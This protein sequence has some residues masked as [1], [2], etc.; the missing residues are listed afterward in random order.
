VRK[1]WVL[2]CAI[3]I[4]L[5]AIWGAITPVYAFEPS[6]TEVCPA[7]SI[8]ARPSEFQ[9]GGI[10]LTY[11]DRNGI[12]VYDIDRATRYPLPDTRPCKSNCRLSPDSR[13]LSYVDPVTGLYERMRMDGTQRSRIVEYA[14]DVQWWS[15][16]TFLIWTPAHRAYLLTEGNPDRYF[17]SVDAIVS[18]QPGGYWAVQM[19]QDGDGF[20]RMLVNLE[21]RELHGVASQNVAL[22]VDMPYFNTAAWSPDGQWFAYAAPV[23]T[24]SGGISA[25]LFGIRP[26]DSAPQQWTQLQD[27]Y[28]PVR[29]N[30]RVS[31]DLSWSPDGRKIAFWVL[32]FHGENPETDVGEAVIHV[33]DIETGEVRAYCGFANAEH[34]P[35]IVRLHWSP[36]SSH[37]AFGGNVPNDDKGY[38]LLALNVETGVFTELSDGIFPALGIPD[39]IA[40][41]IP[42]WS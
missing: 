28:G 32:K 14:N 41:G 15:A 23:A 30:G 3:G 16:Q 22:G 31:T 8:Q 34:S 39:L 1:A 6:V 29:L 24:A 21:A 20:G 5:A 9:P 10:I 17:L 12:W 27:V 2:Y 7:Q 36:D 33:L 35:Q 37:I 42:P 40:W 4:L 38:L 25:E 19:H 11:F 18:V 26:G 13:W